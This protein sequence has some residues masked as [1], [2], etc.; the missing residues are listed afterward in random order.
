[1][2]DEDIKANPPEGMEIWKIK[3]GAGA[4][5]KTSTKCK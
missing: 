4:D 1:M 5:E 2:M 3:N